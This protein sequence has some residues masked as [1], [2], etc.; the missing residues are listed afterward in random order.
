MHTT[1]LF[2][3]RVGAGILILLFAVFYASVSRGDSGP[4]LKLFPQDVTEQLSLTGKV[5]KAME[6]ELKDVIKGFETQLELSQATSCDQQ[7]DEPGCQEIA[8]QIGDHYQKMLD[9]MKN[10]L[11]EMKSTIKATNKGIEKRLRTQLG[12]KSTPADI[13]RMLGNQA[14]PKVTK[15]RFSLSKRFEK[16]HRLISSGAK[17]SSLAK[18]ASEIY[19]D[20]AEVIKWV[21]LMEAEMIRQETIIRLGRMYGTITPEMES[22]VDAVKNI[23][24]GEAEDESDIPESL[25]G[26]AGGFKSP[27]EIE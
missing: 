1:N 24:F 19:L 9:I 11:P 10:N 5:A 6:N 26:G 22:T 23:I 8:K 18:L 27:L 3:G 12:R 15:G 20:S 25:E 17:G 16:Y 13:Q 21:D 2:R 4:A 14:M 7:S